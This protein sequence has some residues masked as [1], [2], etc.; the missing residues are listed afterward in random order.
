MRTA[1]RRLIASGLLALALTPFAAF[2]Q[3]V[4]HFDLPAQP[5][6]DSLRVVGSET[7]T[8]LLFDPALVAGILAPP[9]KADLTSKEALA[10]LLARTG[11]TYR[12]LNRTTA[13]IADKTLHTVAAAPSTLH[14]QRKEGKSTSSSRFR[15]AQDV[16][17]QASSVVAVGSLPNLNSESGASLQEVVVTAEKVREPLNRVPLS[18]T[19]LTA[20]DLASRG[21]LQFRDF[22]NMIPGLTYTTAG[23]GF[24]Q[25]SLRGITTGDDVNSTVGIYVDD[26]PIGT[27]TGFAMGGQLALDVGLFDIAQVDVLRGPQGT[28]Y[29]ANTMG[30]LIKYVTSQP[31]ATQYGG[32]LQAGASYT[33]DGTENYDVTATGNIPLVPNTLA[34]RATGFESRDGGFIDNVAL[35]EHNVNRSDTYGGRTDVLFTPADNLTV[36]LSG[37]LQDISRSGMPTADFTAAGDPVVGNLDQNNPL[38]QPFHQQFRLVSGT[39]TY[40]LAPLIVTSISSYQA[41]QSQVFYDYSHIFVPEFAS[42]GLLYGAVGDYQGLQTGKFTQ[43]IRLASN[44]SNRVDWLLGG[45]Y[46]HE[47]SSD[48]QMFVLRDSAGDPT[49]NNLYSLSTP[50]LFKELAAFGDVTYHVTDKVAVTGGVRYSHNS[51]NFTE[52]GSGLFTQSEPTNTSSEGVYTYLGNARYFINKRSTLYV[53]YATGYRPGGPNYI[54]RSPVTGAPIAPLTFGSDHLRSYEAGL[55]TVTLNRVF[56]ADIDAYYIDWSDIQVITTI[57]GFSVYANAA[58]AKSQGMESHSALIRLRTFLHRQHSPISMH[59]SRQRRQPWAGI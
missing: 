52:Y 12:Y 43:E 32:K 56:S 55:K 19:V 37:F 59:T 35:G 47:M 24:T 57:D 39:L 15:V 20:D 33:K 54:A 16:G 26:V 34:L 27:S 49:P 42:F 25:I 31:N 4:A 11:L 38:D 1:L 48:A 7:K 5:L 51:Q 14:Q 29:G 18:M 30:G 50:S 21:A 9:L 36:R 40:V 6:A 46:T 8:N 10:R 2:A 45:F 13:I 23:P 28:L 3:P 58:A 22:A 17:G 44:G 41:M 53:R